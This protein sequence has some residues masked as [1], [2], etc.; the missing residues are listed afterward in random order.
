MAGPY[1]C[2]EVQPI[3]VAVKIVMSH[4]SLLI[5]PQA[6]VAGPIRK[7]HAV[8]LH[9]TRICIYCWQLAYYRSFSH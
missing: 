3:F 2:T 9:N 5:S 4:G 1:I 7:Q 8:P 6:P